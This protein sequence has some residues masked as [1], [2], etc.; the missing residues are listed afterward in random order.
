[1][2]SLRQKLINFQ[3]KDILLSDKYLS[4]TPFYSGYWGRVRLDAA[5]E[6]VAPL[7]KG[8]LL[9]VGCGLKPHE[10]KFLPYVDK[11][12]GIEYSPVSGYRGNRANFCGDSAALPVASESFDTIIC[13]E[14]LEHVHDPEKTIA[15]FERVLRPGGVVITTAPFVYPVHDEYDFFRY[16]P[17]GISAIMKRYGLT[18][19][20]VKPLSGSAITLAIMFNMY[21]FETGFIWTKWLYPFGVVFR[22]V[23]WL[24]CFVVNIVGLIFET[25]IPSNLFAYN[26][27][28]IARKPLNCLDA[29]S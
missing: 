25:L 18:V 23:L 29:S 1:M 4:R 16:A 12:L 28:T 20:S 24:V 2:S 27:L 17:K 7:A 15:E 22:P 5:L 10:G 14:V 3:R 6:E 13:I 8:L 26:H 9:D 19:D 21:W 11:Y